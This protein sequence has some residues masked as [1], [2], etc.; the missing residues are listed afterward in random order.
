MICHT[1]VSYSK[2]SWTTPR[3]HLTRHNI[4]DPDLVESLLEVARQC[5]AEGRKVPADKLPP[6]PEGLARLG[7]DPRNRK[8]TDYK[9][10]GGLRTHLPGSLAHAR[11][12]RAISLWIATDC[13]PYATVDTPAFTA[14]VRSLDP[15]APKLGRR[16]VTSE[17]SAQSI[18][19]LV[20]TVCQWL[21][22][23]A[24]FAETIG[25][26]FLGRRACIDAIRLRGYLQVSR[27]YHTGL[28]SLMKEEMWSVVRPAYTCDLW[29]SATRKEYM[30]CTAHWVHVPAQG[31]AWQLKRRVV[32]TREVSA[33]TVDAEGA[34]SSCSYEMRH[35]D[36]PCLAVSHAFCYVPQW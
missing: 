4:R 15:Q 8:I 33:E 18:A 32:F 27:L 5:W 6:A 29:T 1:L 26:T 19:S 30:T 20:V 12:K 21:S 7:V 23:F 24:F 22:S 11:V 35:N 2:G 3:Q 13:M 25:G 31:G 10:A 34:W 36:L 14:M 16:A 9:P 28:Q 17:V